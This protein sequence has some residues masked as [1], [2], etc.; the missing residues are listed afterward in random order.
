MK[1]FI[2]SLAVIFLSGCGDSE[3]EKHNL[4]DAWCKLYQRTDISYREWEN[5]KE[6]NLLPGQSQPSKSSTVVVPMPII[7][8]R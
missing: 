2:L 5:L 8:P 3:Q 6:N 7:I 1:K 4:Y